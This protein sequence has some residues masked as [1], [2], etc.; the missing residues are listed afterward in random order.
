[1]AMNLHV[2]DPV[3]HERAL[4][5]AANIRENSSSGIFERAAS[6][7]AALILGMVDG[8]QR[9]VVVRSTTPFEFEV[10]GETIRKLDVLYALPPETAKKLK[11]VLRRDAAVAAAGLRPAAKVRQRLWLSKMVLQ[12]LVD[13]SVRARFTLTDGTVI[14]CRVRSFGIYEINGDVKGGPITVLRHGVCRIESNGQMLAGPWP[15]SPKSSAPTQT[16]VRHEG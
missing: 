11:P 9:K 10:E 1:M 14:S 4:R 5:A 12:G 15:P 13:D 3:L 6:S 2:G 8:S 7:G 16:G